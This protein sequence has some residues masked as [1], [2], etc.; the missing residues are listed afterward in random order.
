MRDILAT[1]LPLWMVCSEGSR[2]KPS[3]SPRARLDT[4][5]EWI[6]RDWQELSVQSSVRLSVVSLGPQVEPEK[7]LLCQL[8]GLAV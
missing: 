8:T 6:L 2:I 5:T 4:S 7:R 1:V 3:L